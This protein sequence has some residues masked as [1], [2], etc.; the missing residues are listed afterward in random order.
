MGM[1]HS[2]QLSLNN[3]ALSAHAL[4]IPETATPPRWS[5]ATTA[6][7]RL[8]FSRGSNASTSVETAM[9]N[10]EITI[11]NRKWMGPRTKT[12]GTGNRPRNRNKVRIA[13]KE[14]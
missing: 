12:E 9:D 2:V 3:P 10:A 7:A 1:P 11:P 14:K 13:P 5:V 6:A 4:S 8:L